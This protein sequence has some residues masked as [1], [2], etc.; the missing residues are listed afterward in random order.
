LTNAALGF[1]SP[2]DIAAVL[3]PAQFT[4]AASTLSLV[5]WPAFR[6]IEALA[7]EVTLELCKWTK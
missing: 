4:G 3:D 5:L 2:Q 6:A 1:A 7:R